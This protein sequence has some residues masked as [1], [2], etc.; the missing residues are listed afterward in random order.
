MTCDHRMG[1]APAAGEAWSG[2]EIDRW[3]T[4]WGE[5]CG[6]DSRPVRE[7][8]PRRWVGTQCMTQADLDAHQLDIQ[9]GRLGLP[10]F[11]VEQPGVLVFYDGRSAC[12]PQAYEMAACGQGVLDMTEGMGAKALREALAALR[13]KEDLVRSHPPMSHYQYEDDL[14]HLLALRA[15][16]ERE[17][18]RCPPPPVN[19]NAYHAQ[20]IAAK[21]EEEAM[22]AAAHARSL[23][24][25]HQER[26]RK[27]NAEVAA[28]VASGQAGWVDAHGG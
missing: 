15:N 17:A 14:R 26:M 7:V 10:M 22:Q 6:Q 19:A 5:A 20:Q 24:A 16:V 4:G 13:A 8:E 25:Q 2:L 23:G 21:E 1:Y 27:R 3:C 18:V 12:E 9:A 28:C 11:H